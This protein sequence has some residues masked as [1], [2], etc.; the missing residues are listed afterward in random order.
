MISVVSPVYN[1]ENCLNE[2][3]NRIILSTKEITSELEIVLVDDGSQDNSW[4]KIKDLKKEFNFI[5]GIKLNKNYGQHEAIYCGIKHASKSIIVVMDCDL[6]DNPEFIPEMYKTYKIK[7]KPVII[8]H[9]YKDF[10]LKDRITSNIFWYFLSLISLKKFS[11]Y[12][13]N[14][15]LID[16][17]IKEKYLLT[18]D[19]SYLY[20]DLINQGNKFILIKKKRSFGIRLKST[21]NFYRLIKFGLI[22][23]KKFNILSN[24]LN[25]KNKVEKKNYNIEIII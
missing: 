2:L 19:L 12:L 16:E 15:L 5:K 24:F 13:G 23:I 3:V 4:E 9:S 17:T 8:Q 14:Y 18:T 10:S 25:N 21:Y 7:G 1:S 20:G 6:Q 11:P 22:L